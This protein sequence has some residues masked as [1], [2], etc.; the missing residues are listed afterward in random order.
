ML[1]VALVLVAWTALPL[2]L[3]VAVGRSFAG[4]AGPSGHRVVVSGVGAEQPA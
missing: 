3:A 1:T 2:P 4:R